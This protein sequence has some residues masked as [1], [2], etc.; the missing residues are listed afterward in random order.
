VLFSQATN[1][2]KFK[3]IHPS[4]I[5]PTG[6]NIADGIRIGW[7]ILLSISD[8]EVYDCGGCR[9]PILIDKKESRRPE[10]C[11]YCGNQIDWVGIKTR[12]RKKCPNCGYT[13]LDFY[14]FVCPYHFPVVHLIQEE[15]PI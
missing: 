15:V 13:P 1:I 4:Q 14:T 9:K 11:S 3:P 5:P 8:K 6:D 10:V 2:D 7:E 12:L